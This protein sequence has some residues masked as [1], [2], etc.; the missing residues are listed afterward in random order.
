MRTLKGLYAIA[1][2]QCIG[3]DNIVNAVSEVLSAGTNIIQY[4]D[5]LNN[6]GTRYMIANKIKSL[7]AKHKALLIVNDDVLLAKSI[8]VDGVHLGKEDCSISEALNYLGPNKI[9]GASCYNNY[10][11]ACQAVKAG[12]NY[13]AF[14]SFF[15]SLTKPS[16]L[17]A[18]TSLISRARKE[19]K[20]PV[21]AIGGITKENVSLLLHTGVDMIAI[22]SAIFS[23]PSPKQ[24]AKEYLT[25]LQQ[26][27]LMA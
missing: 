6:Y 14:G 19:L 7:T 2:T 16:A 23:S 15:S 18:S 12:A 8:D 24:A 17:R 11:N 21:C 1:D 20:V 4:R 3:T 27:D 9:I 25:L 5:K 13:V 22:V 10:D 26:F